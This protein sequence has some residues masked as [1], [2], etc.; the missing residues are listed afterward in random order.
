M[1]IKTPVQAAPVTPQSAPDATPGTPDTAVPVKGKRGGKRGPRG[2]RTGP[3]W[4]EPQQIALA[5]VLQSPELGNTKT[6]ESIA[7]ALNALPEF[8][9]TTVK[10]N[11][12][13]GKLA[14]IRMKAKKDG[15]QLKSWMLAGSKN[16]TILDLFAD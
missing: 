5:K 2:P 1:A 16:R 11:H 6:P 14:A 15:K 3:S 7:E 10:S 9:G 13:S 12:V 4:N 8:E